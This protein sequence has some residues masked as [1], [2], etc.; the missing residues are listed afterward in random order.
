M[1][2]SQAGPSVGRAHR[3]LDVGPQEGDG[4][5][6]AGRPASAGFA[7]WGAIRSASVASIAIAAS[8]RS[9]SSALRPAPPITRPRTPASSA[10]T[11]AARGRSRRT[12]SSP[13]CS[14]GP[15]RRTSVVAVRLST[16]HPDGTLDDDH[17]LV[18]E[19]ALLHEGGAGRV[20]AL[21]GDP[22]E[23]VEVLGVEAVKER[24]PPQGDHGLEIGQR[25][26]R[27]RHGI[28][29][30][31]LRQAAQ[32]RVLIMDQPVQRDGTNHG[33]AD[34]VVLEEPD[35]GPRRLPVTDQI[36]G[37]DGLGPDLRIIGGEAPPISPGA[38]GAPRT[39]NAPSP[40]DRRSRS[41]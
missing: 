31:R 1:T 19:F 36:D 30:A 11:V 40:A 17:E 41:R 37:L 12:A 34:A 35:H 28:S 15:Y 14:P 13:M 4:A 38:S 39:A 2:L 27:V 24:D 21:L 29:T 26:R 22:G 6:R 32:P 3:A 10:M 8:G 33:P 18:A 16:H 7:H 23:P 25:P 9:R 20:P 5:R